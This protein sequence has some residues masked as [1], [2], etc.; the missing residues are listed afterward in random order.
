MRRMMM[1]SKWRKVFLVALL[2]A[3]AALAYQVWFTAPASAA[4][5]VA[6]VWKNVQRSDSYAFTAA[7]ENK[8]IPLATV[9]N[10]GRFSRTA[11]L[12]V[13]GQNSPRDEELQ[14]AMWGGLVNT[15]D[16]EAAYQM[17][18]RD[19]RV[20]TRVGNEAWQPGSDL[21]VGMAPGGDFLAFL[22]VATDI[23]AADNS[24]NPDYTIYQF[25]VDG[26]AYAQRLIQIS[27]DYLVRTNQLPAGVALQVPDNIQA[28]SGSG[29][30]W[31]NA[32]GLPAREIV[33][34]NIPAA[35]GA[36]YRTEA[37]LDV[38]FSDYQGA[39]A[40]VFWQQP[41]RALSRAL[42]SLPLP[43][44]TEAGLGLMALL[45]VLE[46]PSG[47]PRPGGMWP[48]GE[49][50]G[51]LADNTQKGISPEV[52]AVTIHATPEFSRTH[53]ETAPEEV[54]RLLLAEAR[55]WL[56]SRVLMVQQQRWRYSIPRLTYPEPCLVVP[57]PPPLLFAG[58]IFAG[59]RVEGAALSGLAAAA[60]LA[61]L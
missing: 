44:A 1:A 36:D 57:G 40:V 61:A 11:S 12:Y 29:E 38:Q 41:G 15:L 33:T 20:E 39:A 37:T 19:G 9:G 48:G 31:V 14:L 16:Q 5:D 55:P 58:D 27:Q 32:N 6:Q 17:R 7:I 24:A 3:V 26:R 4:G 42:S 8:T 22:D 23:A 59:P 35:A 45:V 10:I 25:N 52:H 2:I 28:I 43:T 47:V 18:L 49:I 46:G 21:N 56:G 54:A 51:W 13:E 30:L 50:I 53:Y 34:L 60:A